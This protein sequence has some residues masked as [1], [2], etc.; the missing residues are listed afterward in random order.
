MPQKLRTVSI[1]AFLHPDAGKPS[2]DTKQ[3]T[4][5][6][7]TQRSEAHVTDAKSHKTRDQDSEVEKTTK[8]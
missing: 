6:L 1:G 8:K 4:C 7:R 2:P 5:E 3:K